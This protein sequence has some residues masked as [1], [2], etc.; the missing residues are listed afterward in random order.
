MAFSITK[1][2]LLFVSITPILG[3]SPTKFLESHGCS[4]SSLPHGYEIW[5]R[6][7]SS[8][9]KNRHP[10]Q[11]WNHSWEAQSMSSRLRAIG[12][13]SCV[14]PALC[15][16][17]QSPPHSFWENWLRILGKMVWRGPCENLD[18]LSAVFLP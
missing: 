13:I 15:T 12:M 6:N 11:S 18:A 1:R 2:I 5:A 9:S 4:V 14:S 17:E 7:S 16:R 10:I 3:A 8:I